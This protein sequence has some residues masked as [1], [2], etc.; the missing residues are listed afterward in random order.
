[1]ANDRF[2]RQQD[3]VPSD[4]LAETT[5]TVIGVGAIGRQVTL[6][7]ASIGA[8]RLQLIDF[9]QVEATNITT[10]GYRSDDLGRKKV[11]ATSEA[12]REIDPDIGVELIADRY[13]SKYAP[14]DAVFVCVDSISARAAIWRTVGNSCGFWAD[15]RMLSEVIRTLV[16]TDL[17]GRD[18]YPSALFPQSDAQPGRCAARS[19]VYAAS[20]AAGLMVH[21]FARWLRGLPVDVDTSFNLLAGEYVV[22]SG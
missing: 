9:D 3:L 2:I 21:Q 1:M 8:R 17:Q 6:Q 12:I 7:L 18:H 5:C 10:Q 20:I 22:G 13:R 19:T 15:G 4:R 14:G 16:V 11:D